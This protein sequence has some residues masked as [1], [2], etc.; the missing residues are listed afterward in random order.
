MKARF[1]IQKGRTHLLLF[2]SGWGMDPRPFAALSSRKYDVLMLFDYRERERL[3]DISAYE[4]VT[5]LA[6]S[7]GVVVAL[8]QTPKLSAS[9]WV[10]LNGTGAFCHKEW[11]IHPRIMARTLEALRTRGEASL[12]AFYANMFRGESPGSLEEFMTRRPERPL[13]D[14]VTELEAFVEAPPVVSVTKAVALVGERDRI[15]PPKAQEA[16]WQRAGVRIVK[17]PWG[18]FPFYRFRY[19]EDLLAEA[20]GPHGPG[21]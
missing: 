10:F 6:W 15:M 3:P 13:E 17:R 21:K 2:F 12:L 11:G 18:H 1:L 19:F 5:V 7:L 20:Y 8:E 14:L 4:K 9:R 16:F